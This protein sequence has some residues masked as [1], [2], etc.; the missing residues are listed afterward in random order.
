M[1]RLGLEDPQECVVLLDLKVS[2]DHRVT[3]E[4]QGHQDL[5]VLK[6]CGVCLD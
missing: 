4:I 1:D 5:L 6:V 2:W 3:M